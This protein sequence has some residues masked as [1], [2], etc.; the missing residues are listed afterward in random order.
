MGG[1]DFLRAGCQHRIPRLFKGTLIF[2][3]DG[4]SVGAGNAMHSCI[5][6]EQA[7]VHQQGYGIRRMPGGKEYLALQGMLYLRQIIL[8]QCDNLFQIPSFLFL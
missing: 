3:P 1:I 8:I 2:N 6:A 7:A 4:D 5:T